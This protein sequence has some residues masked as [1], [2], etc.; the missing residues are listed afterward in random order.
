LFANQEPLTARA[1]SYI[2][3]STPEVVISDFAGAEFASAIARLTRTGALSA[4][5]AAGLFA[6]FDTWVA[7]VATRAETTTADVGAAAGFLRRLAFNL[8]TPDA[9]NI[10]IAQR[11]TASL[12]TFD[13]R[14][15][16]SATAVGLL[17]ATL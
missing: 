7:R 11:T 4:T 1:I 13:T 16:E 6:D 10:A 3:T 15:A 8:R 14:M 12:A 2:Q 17:V 5:Q 9:L